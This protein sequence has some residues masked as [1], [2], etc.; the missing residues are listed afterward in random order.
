M[1]ARGRGRVAADSLDKHEEFGLVDTRL[2]AAARPGGDLPR[3][4]GDVL[5]FGDLGS[6]PQPSP[7]WNVTPPP[8]TPAQTGQDLDIPLWRVLNHELLAEWGSDFPNQPLLRYA[9]DG[10]QFGLDDTALGFPDLPSRMLPNSAT[11]LADP[12]AMQKEIDKES[13]ACRFW[14][15]CP[16]EKLPLYDRARTWPL[17]LTPKKSRSTEP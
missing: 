1:V 13:E 17:G 16:A 14:C 9:C 5:R 12:A 3:Q 15:L 4:P 10:I 11:R 7:G 2:H 8:S 6:S